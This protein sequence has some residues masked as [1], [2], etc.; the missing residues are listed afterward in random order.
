MW[1]VATKPIALDKEEEEEEVLKG[2]IA[3]RVPAAPAVPVV[4][5]DESPR[6]MKKVYIE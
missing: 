5:S 6:L 2:V 4:F 1:V 3:E